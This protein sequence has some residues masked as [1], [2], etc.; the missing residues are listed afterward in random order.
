M[1]LSV[2]GPL[3][4]QLAST[5]L[6]LG[7]GILTIATPRPEPRTVSLAFAGDVML[8]R[9]VAVAHALDGWATALEYLAPYIAAADIGSA[10]LESPLTDSPLLQPGLDLRAPQEAVEAL[11]SAALSLVSLA[12]NHASDAGAEG[13]L[14]TRLALASAGLLSVGPE[15]Q[16]LSLVRNGLRLTWIALD[17]TTGSLDLSEVHAAVAAARATSDLILVSI[18]W[19]SEWDVA[20][21]DRQRLVAGVLASSGADIIVGHHPHVVQSI[22]WVWG[23]GRG[24]PTLV[25]FSL[26]NA[27]FDQASPPATRIGALLLAEADATGVRRACALPFEVDPRTWTAIPAGLPATTSVARRLTP[28]GEAGRPVVAL[29]PVSIGQ[30]SSG[31]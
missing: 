10:N 15:P 20:A 2:H 26:G 12:N 28:E 11:S 9:G 17:D 7:T 22:E 25:A 27:L 24:R 3:R 13:L 29:C 18:H 6:V 23:A 1:D 30:V 19:G 16:P 31:P 5:L 8:G 14:E 21:S 4:A